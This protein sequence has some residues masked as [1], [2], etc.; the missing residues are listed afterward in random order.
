M[1]I[2]LLLFHR[3]AVQ[4]FWKCE[5]TTLGS[6]WLCSCDYCNVF[7]LSNKVIYLF[8]L[9]GFFFLDSYAG[10]VLLGHMVV[11]LIS[12]LRYVH[13]VFHCGYTN[14]HSHQL[15]R[16]V[17]FSPHPHQHLLSVFF[18]V[19]AILTDVRWCLM[20]LICIP[21][22]LATL[23]IFSCTCWPSACLNRHFSKECLAFKIYI[24]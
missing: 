11:L 6:L 12:F 15:C 14:L 21:W 22:W 5:P 20:V 16:R 8:K 1:N 19:I 17:P 13:T 3:L 18:L 7:M 10:V 2:D 4:F 23:S 24:Y 9:V